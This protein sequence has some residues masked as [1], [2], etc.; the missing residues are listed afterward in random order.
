MDKEDARY[1][2]LEQLHER[3]KQVVRLHRKGHGVMRIVELTGLSYPTVRRTIDQ[4]EAG[5]VVAI[6]PAARGRSRGM[7]RSLS[8]DQ[9]AQIRRTICDKRPEQLKMDFALWTRVAVMQLIEREC[10]IRL[11]VRAVGNYLARW[12]FTPQKPIK[13]AYEQRPEAVQQWLNETYPAIEHRAKAECGEIHWGD[14]TAL[15][16]TDVRGR[17]YAP[18]GQTPVAMRVGGTREKLSMIS[19]V[20]N[21]GKASWMIVDGAFNHERLIEFL[22]ALV[23][24]GCKV[25]KKIFLILDNLGVHHCKPV[26]AWLAKNRRHIEVFYLPSYSPEL[27]PDERLNADLKQVIGTKVPVRT[28]AKLHAAATDHMT[29]IEADPQRV[30]SYFQDPRVKYAA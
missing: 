23:K 28:K 5:G 12:G 7:G 13:R 24:D 17:G 10:G 26:K 14:E 6:A 2:T 29:R 25:R 1:Q 9:E 8:A 3:R 20:T 27:N 4:Y 30:K 16:N 21:Q 11:S 22:Q 19:T 18:R 15:V